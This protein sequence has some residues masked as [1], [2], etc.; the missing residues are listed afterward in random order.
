MRVLYKEV[1]ESA[2][3]KWKGHIIG[4]SNGGMYLLV[5][6]K[7]SKN[8]NIAISKNGGINPVILSCGGCHKDMPGN[9]LILAGRANE[10]DSKYGNIIN[11]DVEIGRH[12]SSL[13]LCPE[14]AD[15]KI[16]E[17]AGIGI[18]KQCRKQ[19]AWIEAGV[20]PDGKEV[21]AGVEFE[22]SEQNCL[23]CSKV[24]EAVV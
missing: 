22:L 2:Q 11:A 15:K 4:W 18:C 5:S 10:V 17:I 20:T 21:K 9:E 16:R 1:G 23:D 7:A 12:V 13:F 8:G 24:E 19:I 6:S 3:E 14:C